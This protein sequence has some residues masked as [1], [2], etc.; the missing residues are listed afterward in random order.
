MKKISGALCTG[1][2]L[3]CFAAG[4]AE[5]SAAAEQPL[6]SPWD[7]KPISMTSVQYVCPAMP[8]I[9]GV[10]SSRDMGWNRL[11]RKSADVRKG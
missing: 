7:G 1:V 4:A 3:F 9:R 11:N 6:R 10:R 5:F 2:A 8:N